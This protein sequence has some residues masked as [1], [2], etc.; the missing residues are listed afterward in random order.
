MKTSYPDLSSGLLALIRQ[1]AFS[2]CAKS[3]DLGSTASF[4]KYMLTLFYI[5]KFQTS[6]NHPQPSCK[7]DLK[8]NFEVHME[9]IKSQKSNFYSKYLIGSFSLRFI[10]FFHK[11]SMHDKLKKSTVT[12]ITSTPKP[13]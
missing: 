8:K 13:K 4:H 5:F 3:N 6:C 7:H 11:N 9:N 12:A 2:F 10:T 1:S